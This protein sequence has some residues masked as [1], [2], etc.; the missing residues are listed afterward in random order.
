MRTHGDG[1]STKVGDHSDVYELERP[2]T[3]PPPREMPQSSM[4]SDFHSIAATEGPV[5]KDALA[6][7]ELRTSQSAWCDCVRGR[8]L[9]QVVTRTFGTKWVIV[10]PERVSRRFAQDFRETGPTAWPLHTEPNGMP[11][12]EI[13]SCRGCRAR[14]VIFLFEDRIEQR[15]VKTATLNGRVAP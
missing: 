7:R 10:E 2:I 6:K 5:V 12:T 15:K 4:P 8:V 11:H 1:D 9:A 3:L 13:A 14:W